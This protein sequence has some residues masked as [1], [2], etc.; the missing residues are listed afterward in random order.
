[1]CAIAGILDLQIS[2]EIL[3]KMLRSMARRGPDG[4]GIASGKGWAML[5]SR[6]AVI[7]P[8]GGKQPMELTWAGEHYTIVYNG[9]L[10]NTREL[11][12]ELMGL[13]HVFY[14]HSDTEVLL[15]GFAQWGEG[16]L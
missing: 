2:G 7:D 1:M 12:S 8:E 10:Y 4:N 5:H 11:R 15:H 3:Q 16:V 9:E 6:L 14:T 13:G